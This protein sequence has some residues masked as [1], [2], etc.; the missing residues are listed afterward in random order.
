MADV[1]GARGL[2]RRRTVLKAGLA[3]GLAGV[4]L[5]GLG[6]CTPENRPGTRHRGRG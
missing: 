4:L 2:P 3:A 6:A 5:P 1:T